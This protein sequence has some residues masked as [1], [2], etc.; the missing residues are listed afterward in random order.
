MNTNIKFITKDYCVAASLKSAGLPL[1]EI[2]WKGH[3]A[4]FVFDGKEKCEEIYNR[5]WNNQ[6]KV[7]AMIICAELKNLKYRIM[8]ERENTE[9][10]KSIPKQ[11]QKQIRFKNILTPA[12]TASY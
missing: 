10:Q 5:Y 1:E 2:R 12:T 3:I 8:S 6:L 7:D 9:E 4:F 11:N